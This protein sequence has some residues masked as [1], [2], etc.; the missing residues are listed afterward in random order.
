MRN[1]SL[2]PSARRGMI[3]ISSPRARPISWHSCGD[4]EPSSVTNATRHSELL[5]PKET[6]SARDIVGES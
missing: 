1:G 3:S 4:A 6:L 5:M 2:A